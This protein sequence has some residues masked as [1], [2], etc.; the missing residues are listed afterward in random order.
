MRKRVTAILALAALIAGLTASPI[1]HA[2]LRSGISI[3]DARMSGR[4]V[5]IG[6][7]SG[8]ATGG[9]QVRRVMGSRAMGCRMMT[10]MIA[11]GGRRNEQWRRN[12]H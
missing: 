9:G 2:D 6:Q 11:G 7:G 1:L 8:N 3:I 12:Q 5:A 10:G 4:G